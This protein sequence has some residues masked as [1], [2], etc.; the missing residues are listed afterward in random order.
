[1][2]PVLNALALPL[3]LA[4]PAAAQAVGPG[5]E[6]CAPGGGPAMLVVVTGLRDRAGTIRVRSFGG[7]PATW[8]DKR[9]YIERKVVPTP[10]SGPVRICMPVPRPGH[11][12]VDVRQDANGNG[13]TDR[14]DGGG[15]SGNPRI[16]LMDILF[17]RKPAADKV[18]VTVGQGVTEV[19][20]T[21]MY[22]SGGSFRPVGG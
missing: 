21:M 14:A 8:F 16:S 15:A 18:R 22:L 9:R 19:P 13:D 17:K 7:D 6:R 4:A 2:I 10:R 5:A 11:Y 12:A 20:V 3:T 1:M